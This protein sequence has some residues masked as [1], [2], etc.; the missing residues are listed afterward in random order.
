VAPWGHKPYSSHSTEVI[1]EDS[2]YHKEMKCQ[3]G[4]FKGE[5]SDAGDLVLSTTLSGLWKGILKEVTFGFLRAW[6]WS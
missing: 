2:T 3:S 1:D 5:A 6:L 4:D